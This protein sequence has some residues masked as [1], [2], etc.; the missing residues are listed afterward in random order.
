MESLN[1]VKVLSSLRH[2]NIVRYVESFE[3][4]GKL[5]IV[6]EFAE[7]GEWTSDWLGTPNV[8]GGRWARC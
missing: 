6:M 7:K 1:E 2:P 3:S 4:E 5:C 8:W